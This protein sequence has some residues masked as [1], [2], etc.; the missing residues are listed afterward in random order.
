MG[1]EEF[2]MKLTKTENTINI[3]FNLDEFHKL[4][5]LLAESDEE[6]FKYMY[7]YLFKSN[8]GFDVDNVGKLLENPSAF[9]RRNLV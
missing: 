2:G 5:S 9:N 7:L 8:C 6:Y 4:Q 3:E 1:N